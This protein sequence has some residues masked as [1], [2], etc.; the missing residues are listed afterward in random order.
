MA[1]MS[2]DGS[3]D[4]HVIVLAAGEAKRFGSP[5]QLVRINGRPLLHGVIGRG[6]AVA[7][8]SVIVVLG[9]YATELAPLLRHTPATVIVNRQWSEGMGSSIRTGIAALPGTAE[10]VLILLADQPLVTAE[11]LRRLV[12]VWRRQPSQIVAAQYGTTNGAPAIF[13][14]WT[15]A[16]LGALRGDQG[17]RVLLRRHGERLVRVP[18]ASAAIDIDT[19]EDLLQV[20]TDPRPS[21]TVSGPDD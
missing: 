12:G 18:M 6:V 3:P 10:A 7:G 11:D 20:E 21:A 1:S 8:H 9:A 17:A 13:P 15:F 16:E 4:L 5:K 19:P 14:S 2:E